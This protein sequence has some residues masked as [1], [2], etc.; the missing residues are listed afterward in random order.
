MILEV[1]IK[2][3]IWMDDSIP[4]PLL[5]LDKNMDIPLLLAA[6]SPRERTTRLVPHV[7]TI[8]HEIQPE[9]P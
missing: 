9:Q 3:R 1:T 7:L 4:V 2:A 5:L 8:S 6:K